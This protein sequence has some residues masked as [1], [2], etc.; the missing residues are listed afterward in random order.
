MSHAVAWI[1]RSRSQLF[2]LVVATMLGAPLGAQVNVAEG[3]PVTLEGTF[4]VLRPGSTWEPPMAPA[5]PGSAVVDGAFRPEGTQ[6]TDHTLWW[7]ALAAGSENNAII[8][9]FG[10]VF[11]ISQVTLQADDND[12]YPIDYRVSASDPW[13]SLGYFP[14]AGSFGMVTRGPYNVSFTASQV[15]LSGA[16]GDSYYAISE[17]QAITTTPEPASLALFATGLV[18]L[19]AAARRRRNA[20]VM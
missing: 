10:A 20:N 5:D 1:R 15:R 13:T 4:G 3:K 9:D 11:N 17:F 16:G 14:T 8:I 7:D 6:W 12:I 19:G 2:A 18:G